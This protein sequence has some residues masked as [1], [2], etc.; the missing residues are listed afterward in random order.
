MKVFGIASNDS[1]LVII[2]IKKD[3]IQ[4]HCVVLPVSVDFWKDALVN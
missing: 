3:L 4:M 1:T 2:V